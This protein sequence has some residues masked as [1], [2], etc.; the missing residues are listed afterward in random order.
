MT[1]DTEL[2]PLPIN[3][4]A[5]AIDH[6]AA[7][8][9]IRVLGRKTPKRAIKTRPGPGGKQFSY[10][11]WAY[12][13]DL[14]NKVFGPAWSIEFIGTPERIKLPPIPKKEN[15]KLVKDKD[16]K[17][18]MV[19][20]EE[21]M[22][23]IRLK[24]PWGVQEATASHTYY[25][26]NAEQLYGDVVQSAR[27]KAL[28][29]AAANWGVALDLYFEVDEGSIEEDVSLAE[30]KT[31]WKS[32][33]SR[34]ELTPSTAAALIGRHF[35]DTSLTLDDYLAATGKEGAEAWWTVIDILSEEIKKDD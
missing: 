11:P 9:L 33:L 27:S 22:V 13:A 19:E 10:V 28:R 15:G 18:I 34:H 26:S 8:K 4:P 16:G 21:V 6:P 31:A 29:R 1:K 23:T 20:R 14:L 3:V 35:E 24:T 7:A 25:P 17:L 30:A 2:I 32:A 5:L 12:V